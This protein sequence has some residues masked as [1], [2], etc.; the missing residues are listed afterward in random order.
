M[1]PKCSDAA[2]VCDGGAI[3]SQ[4]T[5]LMRIETTGLKPKSL[6]SGDGRGVGLACNRPAST[7]VIAGPVVASVLLVVVVVEVTTVVDLVLLLRPPL[8]PV[9]WL[10]SAW[11]ATT[12]YMFS[13]SSVATVMIDD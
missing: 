3:C 1:N 5:G 11:S 8:L 10:L 9:L 6:G 7:S 12:Q 2:A 13:P 4:P